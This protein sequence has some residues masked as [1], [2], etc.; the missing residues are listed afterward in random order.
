MNLV[1]QDRD[2]T[3]VVTLVIIEGEIVPVHYSGVHVVVTGV[4][5]PIARH[6]RIQCVDFFP[7]AATVLLV[8]PGDREG[9]NPKTGESVRIPA[10]RMPFFKIGKELYERINQ[11][12]ASLGTFRDGGEGA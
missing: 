7:S 3:H 1:P 9:R 10:K 11:E 4:V 8:E 2:V 12:A 5:T 6:S